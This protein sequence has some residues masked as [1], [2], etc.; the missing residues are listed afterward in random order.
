M[1][2]GRNLMFLPGFFFSSH[3]VCY[4]TSPR[5]PDTCWLTRKAATLKEMFQFF[6]YFPYFINDLPATHI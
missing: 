3:L 2:P 1:N 6:C 5:R 4:F